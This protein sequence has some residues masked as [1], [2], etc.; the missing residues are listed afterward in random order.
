MSCAVCGAPNPPDKRFCGNCGAPLTDAK[1][2][3]PARVA[4]GDA[5]PHLVG[6]DDELRLLKDLF[7]ATNRDRRPRLI[8]VM[9]QAGIGKSRLAAEF[10][11]YVDGLPEEVRW[12][13][14]RSPAHGDGITLWALGEMVRSR[15]GL[16]E[17]D[18]EVTTRSRLR[19]TVDQYVPDGPERERIEGA[20]LT[21]LGLH[22]GTPVRELFGAWRSFF[23]RLAEGA[24]VV[25]VFEDF[26]DADLGLIDFIDHL[27]EWSR[28]VPITVVTLARPELHDK[29]PGWGAGT[30]N[31]SSIYLEPLPEAGMRVLLA[32]LVPALPDE[33]VRTLVARADGAPLYAVETVRGLAAEGRL[34]LVDGGYRIAGDL[35]ALALPDTL[36]ALIAGRLDT[37]PAADRGVLGAAAVLGQSFTTQALATVSG[38]PPADLEGSLRN[39]VRR[40][41][42][43]LVTDPRSPER[44]QYRFVHAL[45]REVADD[46]LARSD[47]RARHLAAA[48]YFQDLH[49][50]DVAGV[51]AAHCVAAHLASRPGAEAEAA[52][53][54]ARSALNGAAERATSLGSNLQALAFLTQALDLT[55]EGSE[56]SEILER[57]ASAAFLAG[58]HDEGEQYANAAL[59]ERTERGDHDGVVRATRI[60]TDGLINVGRAEDAL[61]IIEQLCG[62]AVPVGTSDEIGL[63]GQRAR[64]LYLVRRWQEALGVAEQVLD[65]AE[66]AGLDEVVADTLISK[67]GALA[68]AGRLAEASALM[69]AGTEMSEAGGYPSAM[70]GYV[71]GADVYL[72]TDC[73]AGL[74]VTRAGLSL[75]RRRGIASS[76]I[77]L[78]ANAARYSLRLGEWDWAV[79]QIETRLRDDIA[80]T[81]RVVLS[82]WIGVIEAYRGDSITSVIE[83]ISNDVTTRADLQARAELANV[84]AAVEF[85]QGRLAEAAAGWVRETEIVPG[86]QF[87]SLPLAAR[88]AA[89]ARDAE[90]LAGLLNQF[91]E[92]RLHGGS[93][94]FDAGVMRAALA[95]VTGSA[96]EAGARFGECLL[97]A[98]RLGLRWDQALLG[99]D[100]ALLLGPDHPALRAALP[101]SRRIFEELRA[102]PFVERL[103]AVMDGTNVPGPVSVPS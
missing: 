75:A 7:Q 57:A 40:E 38:T 99:L 60:L 47:R 45:I 37:L 101:V 63:S 24:P 76:E 74:Q 77:L 70:R 66:H 20:L 86:R 68:Y 27:L 102:Q 13:V 55:P 5:D 12:H 43:T 98:Q 90:W 97:T 100:G 3:V 10:L 21:L 29:R 103:D 71:N 18:D 81:D 73:R 94:D 8:S 83:L 93:V 36:T 82:E 16:L 1:A 58:R 14:G 84:R 46:T 85:A 92:L 35:G 53:V 89:W 31:Y 91:V 30:R 69:R 65:A 54:Q 9:G 2:G 34:E 19:A 49:S 64:G 41:I 44:G 95:A 56:R 32:G 11:S 17:T 61:E 33:A 4:E 6:R 80:S 51:L 79:E 59:A 26:H 42:L 67:G 72:A 96:D 78:L 15:A 87:G 48:R 88:A 62:A 28:N 39:L 23:E 22:A 50:G 25:M 52:A